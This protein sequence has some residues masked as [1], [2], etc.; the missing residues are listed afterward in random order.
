MTTSA[1]R[2]A[3]ALAVAATL[4]LPA[5]AYDSLVVFG[6]SLSDNGNNAIVIGKN[7]AQPISNTYVPAQPYGSG[8]YSNGPVWATDLAASLGLPL[9]PS[10]A[11]GTDYAYGGA[12]TGPAA[13]GFPFSLLAQTGQFLASHGNTASSSGL[14]VLAGGGNNAR[15]ALEQLL[16]DGSNFAAVAGDAAAAFATDIGSM[17]DALQAAGAVD[18]LVWDVPNLGLAPA[19]AAAGPATAFVATALSNLMNQAL[20]A[21]LAIEGSAVRT[22]NLFGF[23]TQVAAAPALFGFADATT[24]CGGAANADCSK[25]LWWDGIHPTAAAHAAIAQAVL[26]QVAPIP[27]PETCAL[28]LAG[29]AALGWRA[30][31]RFAA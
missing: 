9:A 3:L 7:A 2:S 26:V 19:V 15:S 18:I 16:P 11:G 29:L 6:D 14:Y 5:A 30:R 13:S 27:E 21:R 31:R 8:T 4:A 20:A 28:M 10:L 17:V 1:L 23:A 24:A 22:F 25:F 12:R